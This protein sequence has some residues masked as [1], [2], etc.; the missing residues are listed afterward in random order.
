MKG[1][2][3]FHL[4]SKKNYTRFIFFFLLLPHEIVQQK[5][6]CTKTHIYILSMKFR[7]NKS[8]EN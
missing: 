1:F 4:R 8:Y 2:L 6:K 5:S 3:K 7:I